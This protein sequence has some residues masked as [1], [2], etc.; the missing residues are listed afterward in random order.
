MMSFFGV[1]SIS[2]TFHW[3]GCLSLHDVSI[4]MLPV[5]MPMPETYRGVNTLDLPQIF[6]DFSERLVV[7]QEMRSV[8]KVPQ[9]STWNFWVLYGDPSTCVEAYEDIVLG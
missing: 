3:P 5:A 8:C 1:R 4:E 2:K 7:N 9:K 6:K